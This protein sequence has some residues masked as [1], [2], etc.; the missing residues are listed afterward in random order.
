MRVPPSLERVPHRARP[1]QRRPIDEALEVRPLP[2]SRRGCAPTLEGL[3]ETSS[4]DQGYADKLVRIA[5]EI[6]LPA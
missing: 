5:N 6:G 4:M 3:A 2:D 1:A